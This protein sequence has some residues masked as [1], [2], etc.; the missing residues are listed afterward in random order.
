[1]KTYLY[2]KVNNQWKEVDMFNDISIPITLKV[3]DI[4]QFGSKSSGYSLDFDIPH[5]TNNAI[6][7]GLNADI[8]VYR[9]SFEVGKDY[10][11]YLSD[12][13]F[14][15]FQ[16]QFRLKK[17][18]KQ[19]SGKYIFYVGYLY[20]GTKTFVDRL[21]TQTL[22]GNDNPVND[23]NFSDYNTPD[24]EMTLSDFVGRLQSHYTDGEDWALTLIDKTNKNNELFTAGS[25]HWSANECTPYLGAMGIFNRIISNSGYNYTS[26]FLMGNDGNTYLT[27]D[28]RWKDTIGKYDV[29]S[30]IYPYM[31]HNSN[32]II[33]I[34]INSIVHQND[35][36]SRFYAI[37][38]FM[39]SS[40][41]NESSIPGF[42]LSKTETS[43]NLN[44]PSSGYYSLNET[45]VSNSKTNYYFTAPYSAYYHIKIN[46]PFKVKTKYGE[47]MSDGQGG[48]V[49]SH[50]VTPSDY[51]PNDGL[52]FVMDSYMPG[53]EAIKWEFSLVKNGNNIIAQKTKKYNTISTRIFLQED[54][55][56]TYSY[57]WDEDILSYE[58]DI[59]LEKNETINLKTYVQHRI[60]KS[61]GTNITPVVSYYTGIQP[62]P[63]VEHAV[64][65]YPMYI[66]ADYY[67]GDENI[68]SIS[69][70]PSFSDEAPFYPS[71]ILNSKTTKLEYFNEFVKMFNLYVEDVSGKKN[72]ETGGIYP[73]KC[74]RIEPYECYYAPQI[75][76]NDTNLKDWTD[77]IDWD[78][79]EYMRIEDYLYNTQKFTKV[80]NKDYFNEQYNSTYIL[81]YADRDIKGPYCTSD[82]KNE[83]ELKTGGYLCGIVNQSTDTLQ[84]PKVFTLDKNG[85]IDT[86][87][88][89]S[90]GIF[91]IWR[92]YMNQN[93]D[94]GT[95]YTI[96]LES[97]AHPGT[98]QYVTNYYCAD[99][100]NKGY[101]LDDANLNWGP[102]DNYY[103]NMKGT[104]PTYNDLYSAFYK[105]QYE[106]YT[107]PDARIMKAKA[108]LTSF[109]IATVQ[110]SDGIIIDGHLWRILEIKEWRDE[111]TPCEIELI[112]VL[113]GVYKQPVET[114]TGNDTNEPYVPIEDPKVIN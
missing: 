2:I 44:L 16:G 41:W 47:F 15:T 87:K 36:L 34:N 97:T 28:D 58:G 32:L 74:L 55:N 20:G 8:D 107:D 54:Y 102:T 29:Y 26:K 66:E 42:M 65:P 71:T 22:I 70:I 57:T 92:N 101:G 27:G 62:D 79:V 49:L 6:L 110:L 48:Y 40:N 88:E 91:F 21:G 37:Q 30:L 11:A 19:N 61:D 60:R 10:E 4:R 56:S 23:L 106:E 7:F 76:Q 95:N 94:I 52:H 50:L 99:T 46:I 85:N 35:T 112:K 12:G 13:C 109:D 1:M 82:E 17:V 77:R 63:I 90:D 93:T 53:M 67:S 72:Y 38:N 108:Y 100:L 104:I 43:V 59:F 31:K 51:A 86:K 81:P 33:D 78:V 25:Q 18:V 111:K 69:N 24:E 64:Y 105:K 3:T 5:T 113:E 14:T 39:S 103:Q 98:Y 83:I 89:Y 96:K 73:E 114:T 75:A 84:C 68:I 45:G 80:Q 9:G